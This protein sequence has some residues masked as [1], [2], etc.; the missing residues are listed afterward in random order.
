MGAVEQSDCSTRV[1]GADMLVRP[2]EKTRRACRAAATR[3]DSDSSEKRECRKCGDEREV[4]DFAVTSTL[5]RSGE[6][7]RA[8]ICKVCMVKYVRG[9]RLLH[10]L[11]GPPSPSCGICQRLGRVVLDHDHAT[12][13][14]R[15]WLCRECKLGL[16][17]LGDDI[18]G[19]LRALA[20]LERAQT[21]STAASSGLDGE[22]RARSRS[23]RRDGDT[24]GAPASPESY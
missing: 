9:L 8:N 5:M 21:R 22:E 17:K 13:E 14:F 2:V 16:G 10:K 18:A 20:Y 3:S 23:P 24:G 1:C 7:Y 19:L 4:T 15:G 11:A 12:G 6:R